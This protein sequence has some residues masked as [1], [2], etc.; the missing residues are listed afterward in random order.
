MR[1]IKHKGFL[2]ALV[3]ALIISS[4]FI[5]CDMKGNVENEKANLENNTEKDKASRNK[6]NP[7][8]NT[9]EKSNNDSTSETN[10]NRF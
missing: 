8:D 9:N 2:I 1:R 10:K 6:E 7:T 3:S 5:A 4:S